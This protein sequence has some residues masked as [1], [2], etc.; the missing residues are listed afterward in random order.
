MVQKE[1]GWAAE[2]VVLRLMEFEWASRLVNEM[3]CPLELL[4]E[5]LKATL[6]EL[7]LVV[8]MVH[9]LDSKS[10]IVMDTVLDLL[11]ETLKE[12]VLDVV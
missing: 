8:L 4:L 11:L 5:L 12:L 1:Q 2:T 3:E 6:R 7:V 9:L 10:V